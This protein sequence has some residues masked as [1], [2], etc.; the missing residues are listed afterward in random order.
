MNF[1]YYEER[2]TVKPVIMLR[3]IASFPN[4]VTHFDVGRE[5]SKNALEQ[6]QSTDHLILLVQQRNP[7]LEEPDV[8][9]IFPTGTI[10]EVKQTFRMPG[11]L[12][13]VLVEGINR[14]KVNQVVRKDPYV[15]AEIVEYIY[16]PELVEKT[17]KMK[18]LMR[19]LVN[20]TASYI[21][22]QSHLAEEVVLPLFD[23]EDPARLADVIT[24]NL[25]LRPEEFDSVLSELDVYERLMKVNDLLNKEIELAKLDQELNEKVNERVNQS[26]KEFMLREQMQLI[27]DELGEDPYDPENIE[28]EYA[29]KIAQLELPQDVNET[30]MKEVE[31]LGYLSPGSPDVNVVRSYLDTIIDLPWGEY[32]E[33]NL[34][35]D[36]SRKTLDR[37][38]YGLKDVKER[39]LEFI[40][41][42]QL[43]GD[44]KG[45]ILC[46][47]GPPGVG[48]TSIARSIAE[49]LDREFT[50]MRLGG[51]TDE[52]EIRGHRKT[53]VGAMPGRII[54][55]MIKAHS[56]NPVFLFDEID[57]IGSDYRGD[58]ASALLEVLDPEQNVEFTDR[59]LEIPFDLSRAMFIT[60]A[61]TTDT[62]PAPL[63]DRM[64]VIRVH[65]YTS[66]EKFEIA[67]RHLLPK[68]RKE[69]GILS[70]QLSVTDGV[71]Q[72][73]IDNYTRESGV[74]ELERMLG[75]I[76]RRAAKELVQGAKKVRVN[77]S[78]QETYLDEPIYLGE[79][80][81]K[82]PEV[83]L[84]TGL[85]WTEVGGV[86]LHI[87]ANVMKGKGNVQLTGSLG[88]VMK[89][90]AL[91]AISYIRARA[92]KYDIDP[93]F[94]EKLDIHIHVPEGAVPKDGPSAG[95][96][97]TTA[98]ISALTKRPVR[99]DVAM[100]GEVTLTGRVLPIGGLKEKVLA[101]ARYK[102]EH[103][104]LPKEN[105]RDLKDI[106][107]E[108]RNKMQF[109][110]VTHV[111]DIL[112]FCLL[113]APKES[114][115]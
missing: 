16:H 22:Y 19:L 50:S 89:E 31:R 51:V 60:T 97:M 77:K 66:Q 5:I 108:I 73:I 56:M 69:A 48:K 113:D 100:T 36:Q 39:I 2:K 70:T 99:E 68:Q 42:R 74:R 104:F 110:P 71:I 33:D 76:C 72:D 87:E 52:S 102:I 30:V 91:A 35:L 81:S 94:N 54:S 8:E 112:S 106:P 107:E 93:D 43:R 86:L 3:G 58:P 4:M 21:G 92:A 64:E 111:D 67:K 40:A 25:N 28:Q 20:Q 18:Q 38:H 27:R 90:S 105:E 85:A 41:V 15:E 13:K 37:R 115:K 23:I 65:S 59:Y 14:A 24:S 47:V 61:N 98:V 12:S 80:I 44:S 79:D 6:A 84:V 83:G 62:I 26:Q 78:N 55:Q 9:D 63:L 17:D 49:A 53:Y 10:A 57:K 11:G 29:D 34:D 32:T 1:P 7:Q 46:L 45:S 88:D 96:T 103:I 75:K 109:H 82:T 101:A 95:V 114:E